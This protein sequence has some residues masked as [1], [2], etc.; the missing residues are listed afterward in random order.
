MGA[1]MKT[2]DAIIGP[3]LLLLLLG[4]L[5]L[6]QR[7][8]GGRWRGLRFFDEHGPVL[9]NWHFLVESR[10]FFRSCDLHGDVEVA[11]GASEEDA[12]GGWDVGIVSSPGKRNIIAAGKTIVGWIKIDPA[13]AWKIY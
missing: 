11:G 12:F 2:D 6:Q 10:S 7:F 4:L 8:G 5:E 3:L 1:A 13:R 9:G